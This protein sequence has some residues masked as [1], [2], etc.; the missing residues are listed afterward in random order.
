MEQNV[1][2]LQLVVTVLDALLHLV[3]SDLR[4]YT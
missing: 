2:A 3:L 1:T 4:Q